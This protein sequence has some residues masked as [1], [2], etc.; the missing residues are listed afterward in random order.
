MLA[1][2]PDA[3]NEVLFGHV[4]SNEFLFVCPAHHSASLP[5]KIRALPSL[6]TVRDAPQIDVTTLACW[7]AIDAQGAHDLP[8]LYS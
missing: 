7:R 2:R 3:D 8:R 5:C 4:N 1:L 6:A